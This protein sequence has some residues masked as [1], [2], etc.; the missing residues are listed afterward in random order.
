MLT[1]LILGAT[2]GFAAAVQPGQLQ[3]YLV[4]QTM[5][6]GWRRTVPA[7]FAPLLSDLPIVTLVLVVLT[8]VPQICLHIL[9]L[10]GGLFLLYLAFGAL[11]ATRHFSR[12]PDGP[13]S[14]SSRGP[15]GGT[16]QPAQ[17]Q[18]LLG[19][20]ARHGPLLLKAWCESPPSGIGSSAPSYVTMILATT[21]IV[22]LLAAAR[23]LGPRVARAL[24]GL[25]AVALWGFGVYQLWA[26]STALLSL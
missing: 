10:V 19:L 18:P 2:Y 13:R 8:R 1:Y 9:Q 6:H 26:G 7:A 15:Q 23:S 11:S 21:V 16:R 25:S 17:P 24:V 20:G 22:M 3:A 12:G 5:T 4:S 14:N